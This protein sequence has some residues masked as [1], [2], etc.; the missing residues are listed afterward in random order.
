[1]YDTIIIG[2]DVSSL[3]A[4][5]AA[6]N[7]GLKTLLIAEGSQETE[8]RDSGYAFPIDPTPLS[9]FGYAQTVSRLIDELNF[10]S[11]DAPGMLLMDPAFQVILPGHRVDV[12]HDPS[13]MITDL[14][15]EFPLQQAEIRRLYHAVFKGSARIERWIGHDKAGRCHNTLNH[16]LRHIIRLLSALA[17]SYSIA[18]RGNGR[19]GALER[20][21]EAQL[22]ILS[23]LDIDA[24]CSPFLS[25]YLLSLPAKGIFYPLGGRKAWITW[26]RK[27]YAASGGELLDGCSVIRIDTRPE[28][29]ID[30]ERD[31]AS[32]T[33]HGNALI[34][35]A[36]WEKL[37]LLLF[38]QRVFR[39]VVRRMGLNRPTGY[40]F[41][42]H[43]GIHQDALPEKMAPYVAVVP[44]EKKS[45]RRQNLVFLEGSLPGETDRAPDGKRALTATVFMEESPLVVDDAQLKGTA[46]T[47]MDSLEPFLPFLRESIDYVNIEKSIAFARQSQEMVNQKYRLKKHSFLALNTLSP[48]TPL[49]NV[50]LTGGI[51]R[52][53]LGFEG[54]ILAGLDAASRVVNRFRS[55][56]Q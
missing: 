19:H 18:V 22:A 35:S 33:L 40:P 50:L 7:Q 2:R 27:Q 52:A 17:G 55:R 15:R 16:A 20:V 24:S 41:C 4:A 31:G 21:I 38:H 25:A 8:Y 26:L 23:H 51:L 43:L 1:M 37:N 6:A 13:Q 11:A 32:S 46:K 28:I 36:N 5:A 39:G 9:G 29:I 48:A 34:V 30:I 44:D 42:L 45:V 54:E 14:I 56:G 3:I 12:F 10:S 49:R 47:I 53:G